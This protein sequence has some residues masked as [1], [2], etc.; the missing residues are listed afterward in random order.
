MKVCQFWDFFEILLHNKYCH[1][2]EA[3]YDKKIVFFT[4]SNAN[5]IEFDRQNQ[6]IIRKSSYDFPH[7]RMPILSHSLFLRR[8]TRLFQKKN[9][10]FYWYGRFCDNYKFIFYFYFFC[11]YYAFTIRT[12]NQ[13]V[14]RG[15]KLVL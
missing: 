4:S 12:E 15:V 2:Y 3:N 9:F 1:S 14:E 10:F 5:S 13:N 8:A 7:V 6:P 11:T